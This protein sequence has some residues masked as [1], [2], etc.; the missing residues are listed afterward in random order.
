M[1]NYTDLTQFLTCFKLTDTDKI[2][3]FIKILIYSDYF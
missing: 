1:E 3:K 2:N